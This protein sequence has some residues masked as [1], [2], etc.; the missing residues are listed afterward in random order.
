MKKVKSYLFVAVVLLMTVSAY[1]NPEEELYR[2]SSEVREHMRQ[3]SCLSFVQQIFKAL[4]DGQVLSKED[5][6][7]LFPKQCSVKS[8]KYEK[9]S[10]RIWL[11]FLYGN[12]PCKLLLES[13]FIGL[14]LQGCPVWIFWYAENGHMGICGTFEEKQ[15]M[16]YAYKYY[17]IFFKHLYELLSDHVQTN[18]NA[19]PFAVHMWNAFEQSGYTLTRAINEI[20]PFEINAENACKFIQ[21]WNN[22]EIKRLVAREMANEQGVSSASV[23][24]QPL[25]FIDEKPLNT[26]CCVRLRELFNPTVI[27]LNWMDKAV[28]GWVIKFPEY[29]KGGMCRILKMS[30]FKEHGE[31]VLSVLIEYIGVMFSV[32]FRNINE[33]TCRG[34]DEVTVKYAFKMLTYPYPYD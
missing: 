11:K 12:T 26:L 24:I 15:L 13:D 27:T 19:D 14:H 10:G 22:R 33:G 34:Y 20:P 6:K 31:H 28:V 29:I 17:G 30:A 7:P 1:G 18:K 23:D 25:I 9:N 8:M 16:R 2:L 5:F 4:S 3:Y 32:H 21:R